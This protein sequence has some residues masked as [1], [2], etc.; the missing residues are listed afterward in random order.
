M[1]LAKVMATIQLLIGVRRCGPSAPSRVKAQ[2]GAIYG[3]LRRNRDPAWQG[4][5]IA[6]T[7]LSHAG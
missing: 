5:V 7:E 1:G 6:Q 3:A 4:C 2:F